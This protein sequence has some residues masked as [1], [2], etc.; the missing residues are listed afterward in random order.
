MLVFHS[1]PKVLIS[2]STWFCQLCFCFFSYCSSSLSHSFV[3]P[4]L[5][6]I[7]FLFLFCLPPNSQSSLLF[8]PFSIPSLPSYSSFSLPPPALF[9]F[10]IPDLPLCFT[11]PCV[12]ISTYDMICQ[13]HFF[14]LILIRMYSAFISPQSYDFISPTGFPSSSTSVFCNFSCLNVIGFTY[15]VSCPQVHLLLSTLIK[16]P[17]VFVRFLIHAVETNTFVK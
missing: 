16:V 1:A 3:S 13:V 6:L 7:F 2:P 14:L 10:L 11:G 15:D 8:F 12:I 5:F 9:F 17:S 4:F